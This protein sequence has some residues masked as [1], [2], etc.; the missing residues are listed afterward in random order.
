[1]EPT[2]FDHWHGESLERDVFPNLLHARH[3]A[4]FR[5]RGFFKSMDTYKDQQEMET[6]FAA[7]ALPWQCPTQVAA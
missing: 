3:L 6:L 2:I 7:G 5:H 4:A 1:M